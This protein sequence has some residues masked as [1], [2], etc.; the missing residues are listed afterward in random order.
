MLEGLDELCEATLTEHDC[1]SLSVAVAVGGELALAEAYGWADRTQRLP[2]APRTAY[3]LASVTKPITA[4]AVC[5]AADERLLH[6]D[7]PVPLD[8]G[9][10]LNAPTVRQLL[11]HTGG[12]AAHYDFHYGGAE[13][14]IDA[15]PYTALYREPGS[16]FEYAN[17]GYRLLGQVLESATGQPLDEFVRERVF[18]PLG[19]SSCHL[20][21]S[22]PGPGASAVRYTIDGRPY[23]TACDTSHP[24]ASLGWATAPELALF[25]Q[26]C[27]RLLKPETAAATCDAVPVNSFLGYGLGWCLSYGAGPAIRSHGGGMGGVAAM[28]VAVPAQRLSV[29]VLSN[30]T[31]K[32]ARD[33]VVRYV[34]SDLVPGF[35]PEQ[36]SP[37]VPGSSRPA[38]LPQGAWN[39][40]ISTPEGDVHIALRMPEDG[41]AELQMADSRATGPVVCSKEREVRLAFP[42][43]LP[44]A[45]ARV[46][47][48]LLEL[49][50]RVEQ[51][52]LRGVARACKDGD[53]E[54]LLGNMLTHPCELEPR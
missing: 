23:P 7:S 16:S 32:S 21:A 34:L 27:N 37:A 44:T 18:A 25:A 43:Q 4:T 41:Q 26:S 47:S 11:Q 22:Y 45:D 17:L 30:S 48:P 46:N 38:R 19:L 33:A 13:R 31:N 49:E 12:L 40:R 20:G 29:A 54:G 53:R 6:L 2:A 35:R 39:G 9:G 51:G 15:D 5:L 28:T 36:I 3:A 42:L 1:P 14:R 10:R 24:G 50:L 8:A 52:R